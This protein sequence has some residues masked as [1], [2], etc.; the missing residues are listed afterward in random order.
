MDKIMNHWWEFFVKLL[1]M[2]SPVLSDCSI[3]ARSEPDHAYRLGHQHLSNRGL[4]V[5]R[6]DALPAGASVDY[7]LRL[8][9]RLHVLDP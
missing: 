2:A 5:P 9:L 7:L 4:P 1:P 8:P 3:V 6:P